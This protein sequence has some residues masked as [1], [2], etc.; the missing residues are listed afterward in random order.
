MNIPTFNLLIWIWMATGAVVF[1]IL[2]FITAPY[3]RHSSRKWGITVPDRLGWFMMEAPALV[4]F[5]TLVLTGSARPSVSLW[6]I[7]ILY[8]GHYLN[9][10]VIYPLRIRTRGKR[11][12][13][14]IALM[15]IVFNVINAGF[16]GYYTGHLQTVYDNRWL[17]DP[18]FIAGIIIFV[19]GMVVN[20][21]SDNTLIHLREMSKNG[22]Q[23]PYGGLFRRISC[24]NFFGELTEWAGYAILC[25]SLPSLS[26]FVWTACNL[27]PRALSHHRWYKT[28]FSDYPKERK[29]VIPYIL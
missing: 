8:A 17:T 10:S 2:L 7:S 16:L 19:T 13:L 6:I 3:G 9:R 24:P 12:P 28:T 21:T 15:A 29:A 14:V 4:I 1:L 25:W 26:F 20:I 22:Y 5:V 23:I 11:M 18:R 27:V